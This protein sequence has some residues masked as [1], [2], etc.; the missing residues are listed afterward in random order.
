MAAPSGAGLPLLASKLTP[1]RTPRW[2]VARG[3]LLELLDAG[4]Q[5]RLT[6]LTGPAGS[7]KTVLLSSWAATAELPGPVAWLSLDAADNDPARF[8]SYLLAALRQTGAAPSNGRL[9]GLGVPIG[10][11]DQGFLLE[12]AAGLAELVGPVVVI[13]DDV[14]QLTNPAL[15]DS[16]VTVLRR[17]PASLRLVLASREDL[18]LSQARL[19]VAG[20]SVEV[21]A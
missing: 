4:V 18:P 21:G 10:G 2:L 12:L 16:L 19:L 5:G 7:G 1:P 8:W 6:L 13:L 9:D 3:R 15:L 14:H 11:P 17:S 20:P